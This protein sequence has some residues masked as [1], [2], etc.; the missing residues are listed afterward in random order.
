MAM[1]GADWRDPKR[2]DLILNMAKM[3]REGA[4]RVIIE[5]AKLEEYEPTAV[6]NQAFNDL[7]L[8]SLL[9]H[10]GLCAAARTATAARRRQPAGTEGTEA[11]SGRCTS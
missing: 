9:D 11:P 3:R 5:A 1:F 7:A 10:V 4:K 8:G 6:S 2:Y